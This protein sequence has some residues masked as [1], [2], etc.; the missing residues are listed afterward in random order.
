MLKLFNRETDLGFVW[1][2]DIKVKCG[3]V[4]QSGP[5]SSL[6]L[7]ANKKID[8][9][10]DGWNKNS[11]QSCTLSISLTHS[12]RPSFSVLLVL[13]FSVHD[14]QSG[15]VPIHSVL[16]QL[17]NTPATQSS[18]ADNSTKNNLQSL[19]FYFFLSLTFSLSVCLQLNSSAS[20]CLL[21]NSYPGTHY[22]NRSLIRDVICKISVNSV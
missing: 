17:Q 20:A 9:I 8:E 1:N 22:T 21:S 10:D 2:L 3:P 16:W 14:S 11:S 18:T 12:R 15:C 19:S 13:F 7:S 4:V 6:L 5:E